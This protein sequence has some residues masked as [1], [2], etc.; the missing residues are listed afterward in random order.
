MTRPASIANAEA[1]GLHVKSDATQQKQDRNDHE[2][3]SQPAARVVAPIP[4]IRPRRNRTDKTE[5]QNDEENCEQHSTSD[6][7]SHHP[8]DLVGGG[9]RTKEEPAQPSNPKGSLG[10]RFL[11]F[12]SPA[13][14]M[15]GEMRLRDNTAK[16]L[17]ESGAYCRWRDPDF[18]PKLFSFAVAER[19][20]HCGPNTL[21]GHRLDGEIAVMPR[22]SL[23]FRGAAIPLYQKIPACPTGFTAW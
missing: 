5:K 20:V 12:S 22:I 23:S 19:A 11:F 6:C 13:A 18:V 9:R 14:A 10:V 16:S 8:A 15:I 21:H 1:R 4:A 2:D 3:H 7:L 17:D